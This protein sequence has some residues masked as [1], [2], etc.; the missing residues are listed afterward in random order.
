MLI[1]LCYI[2]L[3]CIIY[4]SLYHLKID[5]SL[6]ATSIIIY[7]QLGN[8][9]MY[10]PSIDNLLYVICEWPHNNVNVYTCE[11]VGIMYVKY[12]I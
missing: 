3:C 7:I 11:I 8:K 12:Y 4:V 5:F 9:I 1:F 6:L 2:I 10:K